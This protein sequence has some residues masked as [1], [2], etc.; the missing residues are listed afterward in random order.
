MLNPESNLSVKEGLGRSFISKRLGRFLLPLSLLLFFL[1]CFVGTVLVLFPNA[2]LRD[3]VESLIQQQTGLH[4]AIEDLSL[5][6]FLKLEARGIA[7]QP[8]VKDWPPVVVARFSLSPLW[9]TLFGSNPAGRFNATVAK[10]TAEGRCAK[11]GSY[12]VVLAGVHLGSII[13]AN[14]HFPLTGIIAGNI[15]ADRP[16]DLD[17]GNV[18]FK[19]V[20][21]DLK[22]GGLVG[23]GLAA[24]QLS[25]GRLRL[26]GKIKGQT[27][28]LQDLQN[29]GG[30]LSLAGHGIILISKLPERCRLNLQIKMRLGAK[31][32]SPVL[33]QL[34]Q[35]SRHKPGADGTYSF[36]LAGTLARP[37]LR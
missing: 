4:I 28:D 16:A 22:V 17:S 8:A 32:S 37:I 3:R 6:P 23:L 2:A 18:S 27:F 12:T 19:L 29:E 14:S 5:S 20:A 36:R 33:K 24:N 15:T 25:L 9:T 30:E 10:G 13:A 7:W 11:D 35:L 31:L 1:F 26:R 34:L 21:D